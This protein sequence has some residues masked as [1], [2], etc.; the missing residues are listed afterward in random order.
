MSEEEIEELDYQRN[1]DSMSEFESQFEFFDSEQFLE[2]EV[3][4]SE[5]IVSRIEAHALNFLH[6][7]THTKNYAVEVVRKIV[8]CAF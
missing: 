2:A 3:L 1:K 8:P 5:E 7:I 4:L 6:Q